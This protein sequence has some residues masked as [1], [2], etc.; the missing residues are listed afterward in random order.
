MTELVDVPPFARVEELDGLPG[1]V[2]LADV[3]WYLDGRSG[4][5]AY[6]GDTCRARSSRTS[7]AG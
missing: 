5:A 7:T 4:R 2:V 1:R 3:R 6:E